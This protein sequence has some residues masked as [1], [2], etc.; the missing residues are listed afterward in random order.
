[1]V[2]DPVTRLL[3]LLLAARRQ[4][5]LAAFLRGEVCPLRSTPLKGVDPVTSLLLL[6]PAARRQPGLAAS[7]CA[8]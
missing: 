2:M 4:P 6:L 5:G 1:M 8:V 7:F 3:L